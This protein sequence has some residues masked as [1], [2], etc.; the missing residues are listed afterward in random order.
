[1]LLSRTVEMAVF[2]AS[3]HSTKPRTGQQSVS[4][5]RKGP[6]FTQYGTARSGVICKGGSCANRV[7]NL[8]R[9]ING[10]RKGDAASTKANHLDHDQLTTTCD[11]EVL[12]AQAWNLPA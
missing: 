2:E 6:G 7:N 5:A 8:H 11:R 3:L 4:L 10:L 1:M 9:N 12:S